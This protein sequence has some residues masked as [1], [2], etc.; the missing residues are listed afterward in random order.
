MPA[1]GAARE[2]TAEA[3]SH[4]LPQVTDAGEYMRAT[5]NPIADTRYLGLDMFPR[6]PGGEHDA[7]LSGAQNFGTN[8]N[9][10]TGVA[11]SQYLFDFGWVRGFAG[12]RQAESAAARARLKLTELDLIYEVSRRYLDLL[13]AKQIVRVYEK[14]VAQRY[15][16]DSAAYVNALYAYAVAKAAVDRDTGRSLEGL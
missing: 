8:D 7:G 2:R 15:T 16:A 10:L 13:A 12:Q 6:L 3:R 1:A 14:A 9:Y 11:V 5:D 4:L